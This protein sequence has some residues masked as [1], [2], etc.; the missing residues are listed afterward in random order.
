MCN[1]ADSFA[2][3]DYVAIDLGT[4]KYVPPADDGGWLV[5]QAAW[6][7]RDVYVE[8]NTLSFCLSAPTLEGSKDE[9]DW[10]P[11]DWIEI[12]LTILPLWQR[13]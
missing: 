4:W 9:E 12:K 2:G 3:V 7:G 8:G 13:F 10:I 6:D 1:V 5:G 11:I